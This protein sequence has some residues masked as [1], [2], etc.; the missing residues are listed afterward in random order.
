MAEARKIAM[1]SFGGVPARVRVMASLQYCSLIRPIVCV[2]VVSGI[3][4]SETFR[5]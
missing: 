4:D 1:G 2:D 3:I 5:A